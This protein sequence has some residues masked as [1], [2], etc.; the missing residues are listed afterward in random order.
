MVEGFSLSGMFESPLV[1]H[2]GQRPGPA[3]GLATRTEQADLLFCLFSGHGE[4]PRVI[5]APGTM[6]DAFYLT[7][8][9][10]DV[11]AKYQIP[12]IILTDQ[13]FV[14]SSYNIPSLDLKSAKLDKHFVRTDKKYRRYQL[15]EDGVSPR[16]IPGWGDGLVSACSDEHD[17]EGHITEDRELRRKMVEKR[18]KKMDV[19]KNEVV[20]PELIGNKNYHTLILGWGA[21]RNVVKEALEELGRAE[22]S[23]LHFKQV[24]PL[25]PDTE[26]YV[27]NAKRAIIIENNATAQF[28]Q[29]I[30]LQA[31]IDVD[32]KILKYDGRPFSKEEVVEKLKKE[33]E[34]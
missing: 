17:E 24:Y 14:D 20:Q 1:V 25:H 15:T 6:E 30:K 29:L 26:K 31:G 27:Q 22:I 3:T 33:M 28:G 12:A 32:R 23:F 2:I 5:Y 34:V 9:A 8:K 16:G 19:I 21:T 7:A 10:F 4:F 11:A 13:H 18:L